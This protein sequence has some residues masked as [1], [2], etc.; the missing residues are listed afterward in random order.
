MKKSSKFSLAEVL[1][2]LVVVV[3]VVIVGLL[4]YSNLVVS[5]SDQSNSTTAKTDPTE[6]IKVE[7]VSDLEKLESSLDELQLEDSDRSEL[8]EA[9]DSF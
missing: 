7:N 2:I 6:S 8:N 9:I 4:A 3:A 5:E 1:L